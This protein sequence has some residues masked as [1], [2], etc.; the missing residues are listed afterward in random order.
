MKN[1]L[2]S[3]KKREIFIWVLSVVI[4]T[5]SFFIGEDK[6]YVSLAASLIGATALIF[7]AKGDFIGQFFM[8]AF[9]ILYAI[10]SYTEAYYGEMITYLGMTLPSGVISA[11]IWIKNT[12]DKSKR[13]VKIHRVSAR[14]HVIIFLLTIVVTGAFYFI[15]GALNTNNLIVSTISVATSFLASTYT[16]LRS[17]YFGLAY[18]ANDVVL[19]VLWSMSVAEDLSYLPMLMCFVAFFFN[20]VYSF[21]NWLRMK[22]AQTESAPAAV[23][24]ESVSDEIEEV[25]E[26]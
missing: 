18:A 1:P 3:F 11:I 13:E 19:I 17:P 15:L 20:D 10:V 6:N 14:G 5:A 26:N 23:S 24:E 21:I 2:A 8:I 25:V 22:K 16:F 12:S 9:A 7:N 4:I